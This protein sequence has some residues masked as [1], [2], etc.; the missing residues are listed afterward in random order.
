VFGRADHSGNEKIGEDMVEV[1]KTLR[2]FEGT[3]ELNIFQRN[4]GGI[5]HL[6]VVQI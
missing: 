3:D 6:Y 2:G 4:V 5:R 1:Y